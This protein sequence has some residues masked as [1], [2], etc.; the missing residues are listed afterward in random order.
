LD[1]R[2]DERLFNLLEQVQRI[3]KDLPASDPNISNLH[4]IL[5]RNFSNLRARADVIKDHREARAK[6]K[7]GNYFEKNDPNRIF[8]E[9]EEELLIMAWGVLEQHAELLSAATAQAI[10]NNGERTFEASISD[11]EFD[12][13]LKE[14]NT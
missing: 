2:T 8:Q 12:I 11:K 14:K 4:L 13:I 10:T 3:V 7:K 6:E 9:G 5:E 1:A